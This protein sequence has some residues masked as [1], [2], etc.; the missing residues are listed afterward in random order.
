M[1]RST[2]QAQKKLLK[3]FLMDL[4]LLYAIARYRRYVKEFDA[5]KQSLITLLD[6]IDE[7]DTKLEGA[8]RLDEL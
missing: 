5:I 2:L 3:R 4:R 6:Q 1:L 8:K 7:L